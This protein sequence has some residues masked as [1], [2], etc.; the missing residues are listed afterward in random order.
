MS[1]AVRHS[2]VLS[3]S[4]QVGAGK[5]DRIGD[6]LLGRWLQLVQV[7]KK[8]ANKQIQSEQYSSSLSLSLP[9]SP[10][11]S[12]VFLFR[13]FRPQPSPHSL[14]ECLSPRARPLDSKRVEAA[15]GGERWA[16]CQFSLEV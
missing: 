11:P 3:S 15:A 6:T 8:Q 16:N 5:H 10:F 7:N 14:Y 4:I 13:R 12:L 1:A 9:L 2:S